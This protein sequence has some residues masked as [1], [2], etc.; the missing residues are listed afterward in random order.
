[1][2]S[3]Y[4]TIQAEFA[5]H[6]QSKGVKPLAEDS[7]FGQALCCLYE[8]LGKPVHIDKIREYVQTKG[9]ILP[10][11]GDS[12]QVR[13]IA[14]QCGYNMI[15]GGDIHPTTNEKIPKSHYLLLDLQTPCVA[16][17]PKRRK[18]EMTTDQWT[19][20]K[21]QYEHKCVNCGA[22]EGKP[23]RWNPHKITVLQQ[24]H[25]DPRKELTA[26]NM[27]PQCAICNQQ[28][29]NKAVFNARGFV[30]EFH[31]DGFKSQITP[32]LAFQ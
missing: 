16:F 9:I 6:L 5:K 23:L 22:E 24:G 11:G 15:K 10:G 26:S 30:I 20:L 28:Y 13:H 19:D 8:N 17:L 21:R 31:K 3:T 18:V 2:P 7:A 12:L 27:I 29:K 14:L 32:S 1:M 4:E 25:M